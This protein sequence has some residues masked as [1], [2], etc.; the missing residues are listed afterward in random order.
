LER[1][2]LIGIIKE[3]IDQ[4]KPFF[5]ICLGMQLLLTESE[6]FGRYKG[7]DVIK[8]RVVKF[9]TVGQDNQ[10][11]KVPQVGWNRVFFNGVLENQCK[12]ALQSISDGEYMY[13]VH[14]YYAVPSDDSVTVTTTSYEGVKYCSSLLRDSVFAVQFHPEKS[15]LEGLKIYKNW[16][17]QVNEYEELK[18]NELKA[19]G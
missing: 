3:Q 4:K 2:D 12:F 17:C 19:R 14:S 18:N 13:F 7:F 10:K 15:G 1:L 16:A 5:G 9:N 6:E 8:G 11:I